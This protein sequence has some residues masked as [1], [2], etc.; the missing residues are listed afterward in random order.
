[1]ILQTVTQVRAPVRMK[2]QSL[3]AF[4]RSGPRLYVD[5]SFRERFDLD[6]H[7]QDQSTAECFY[8]VFLL[9]GDAYDRR[10]RGELPKDHLSTL[11]DVAGFIEAQPEGKQGCL[12]NNGGANIFYVEGKGREVFAVDV[13]WICDH[14][15]WVVFDWHLGGG[16]W[17]VGSQVLSP[18]KH[19]L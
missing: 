15:K 19:I 9:K 13:C 17:V 4:Y 5:G 14:G 3:T 8:E 16:F 2:T 1:M 11:V 10:I 12:L 7:E 6:A 18:R